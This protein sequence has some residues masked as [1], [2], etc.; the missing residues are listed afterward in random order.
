[1][2]ATPCPLTLALQAWPSIWIADLLRYLI[3]VGLVTLL[4]ARLPA[5]WR[6]RRTV[7]TM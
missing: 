5:A 1:M 3:P 2:P 6:A 4:V 7:Q